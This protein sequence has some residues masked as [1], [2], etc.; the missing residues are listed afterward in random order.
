MG[1]NAL[2]FGIHNFIQQLGFFIRRRSFL[3]MMYNFF[4]YAVPAPALGATAHPLRGERTALLA[5]ISLFILHGLSWFK[6][7]NCFTV[8]GLPL[9]RFSSF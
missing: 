3:H 9:T 8:N 4:H 5:Y 1:G 6:I 2:V 7:L